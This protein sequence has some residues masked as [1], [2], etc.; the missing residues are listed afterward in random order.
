[1]KICH[2]FIFAGGKIGITMT[3]FG[4]AAARGPVMPWE[5]PHD[6][7][8]INGYTLYREVTFAG[9]QTTCNKRHQAIMSNSWAG[10]IMHPIDV[11]GKFS[12]RKIRPLM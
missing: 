9:F 5:S 7:P 8:G 3:N 6:Y 1:M 11:M 4:S 2:I 12:R 10:D